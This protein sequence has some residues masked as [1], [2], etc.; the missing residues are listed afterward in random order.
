MSE[1]FKKGGDAKPP[2]VHKPAEY[3]QYRK[4]D[5]DH[6]GKR[7][8]RF[9]GWFSDEARQ[10]GYANLDMDWEPSTYADEA[11]YD[12][13]RTCHKNLG[14]DMLIFWVAVEWFKTLK[15]GTFEFSRLCGIIHKKFV[16][17]PAK[18]P[19]LPASVR[20]DVSRALV[21]AVVVTTPDVFDECQ[22]VVFETLFEGH[23]H[24]TTFLSPYHACQLGILL[25]CPGHLS[26]SA[27]CRWS[28]P[29]P[30]WSSPLSI[31]MFCTYI[32]PLLMIQSHSSSCVY[33][34]IYL[35][36]HRKIA[37]YIARSPS[38]RSAPSPPPPTQRR[39]IPAAFSHICARPQLAIVLFVGYVCSSRSGRALTGVCQ[40]VH[41]WPEK[42]SRSQSWNA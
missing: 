3:R 42:H 20:N 26:A 10:K 1:K 23:I 31:F 6:K 27:A 16:R 4:V 7:R 17:P 35:T 36:I 9:V 14:T 13:S 39:H 18:M 5:Y 21:S 30:L 29:V 15:A 2:I 12:F 34:H 28:S 19:C 11:F 38:S 8:R 24:L 37:A 33:A 32:A 40:R 41:C 22:A 25:P